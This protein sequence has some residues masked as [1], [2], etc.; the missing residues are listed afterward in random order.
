MAM[1][2]GNIT[3][4]L[5]NIPVQLVNA[6]EDHSLSLRLL[7]KTDHSPIR[8]ARVCKKD[9]HEVPWKDIVRGYE[10]GKDD[11]VIVDQKELEKAAAKRTH[12][13]EILTFVDED[14]IESLY[15]DKPYYIEPAK[16][17]AKTYALLRE[18]LKRSGKVGVAKVV[19]TNKEH[20]AAVKVEGDALMLETLRFD[21]EVKHPDLDLP[22]R[23][24]GAKGEL[25]LALKLIEQMSG[26][27][28]P[29]KYKDTYT[30]EL[31]AYIEKKAQGK[32]A[33]KP[34]KKQ[35]APSPT[36]VNELMSALKASLKQQGD[37]EHH[38]AH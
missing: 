15:F 22:A 4:S 14:G 34:G 12:S 16:T 35:K 19:F 17:G 27:F 24:S 36:R 7:H 3:F 32:V 23:Y 31:Q 10:I 38:A 8:F 18:A 6:S 21:N 29:K 30:Q 11:Y 26:K 20:L 13:I 33:V 1:W 2:K 5:V 9:G 28:E 37:G 25:D